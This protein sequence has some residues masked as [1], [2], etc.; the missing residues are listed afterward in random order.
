MRTCVACRRV[1]APDELLRLVVG[2]ESDLWVDQ[3]Q[4]LDGRGAY[5]CPMRSCVERLEKTPV[6]LAKALR[7]PVPTEGLLDSVRRANQQSVENLLSLATRAGCVTGG[8]ERLARL[9][10]TGQYA[11]FVVAADASPRSVGAVTRLSPSLPLFRVPLGRAALG[12]LVGR[13]ER[14]VL[15]IRRVKPSQ[16][17]LRELRR[18][19]ALG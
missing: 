8:A 6:L 10:P 11:C 17:L 5:V 2:P 4:R 1:A 3:R 7:R 13:G 12:H 19:D 14:A 18:M 15:A 9:V 16:S